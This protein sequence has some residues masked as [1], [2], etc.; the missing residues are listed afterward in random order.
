M[1]VKGEVSSARGT[2]FWAAVVAVI[3]V[4]L[5]LAAVILRLALPATSKVY[6]NVVSS[7]IDIFFGVLTAVAVVVCVM[8]RD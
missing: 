8:T 1:S 2:S 4:V 6:F 7:Q 3:T 5:A